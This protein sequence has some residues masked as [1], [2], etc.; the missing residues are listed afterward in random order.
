MLAYCL[1]KLGSM[2]CVYVWVRSFPC[3]G[4]FSAL[5]CNPTFCQLLNYSIAFRGVHSHFQFACSF[6]RPAPWLCH[7]ISL[8]LFPMHSLPLPLPPTLS[9]FIYLSPARPSALSRS[10]NFR[11]VIAP[12]SLAPKQLHR[13]LSCF[14]SRSKICCMFFFSSLSLSLSVSL[15]SLYSVL[16]LLFQL[17]LLLLPLAT[18]SRAQTNPK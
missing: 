2:L 5:R 4:C 18:M 12:S 6:P 15:P 14:V 11:A 17:L 10:I 9:L 1:T 3:V 7:L 16:L 13:Q 8:P